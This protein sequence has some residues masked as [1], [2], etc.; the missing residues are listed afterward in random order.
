MEDCT[1]LRK[2]SKDEE[3]SLLNSEHRPTEARECL[4]EMKRISDLIAEVSPSLF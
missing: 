4:N 1:Y 2:A 3:E